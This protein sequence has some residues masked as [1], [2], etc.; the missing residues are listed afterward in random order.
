M[1]E[2]H[3]F[4][5]IEPIAKSIFG[6][7]QAFH[8]KRPIALYADYF[9]AVFKECSLPV[10]ESTAVDCSQDVA[11]T[12]RHRLSPKPSVL[13]NYSLCVAAC[14]LADAHVSAHEVG[15]AIGEFYPQEA[16]IRVPQDD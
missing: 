14:S 9:S 8:Y 1:G 6:G 2:S 15:P 13:N 4:G 3:T 7:R 16:S 10:P 11:V 12:G 5:D